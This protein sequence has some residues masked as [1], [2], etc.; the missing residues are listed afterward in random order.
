MSAAAHIAGGAVTDQEWQRGS[1]ARW[2][3]GLTLWLKGGA[4]SIL[5]LWNHFMLSAN[6]TSSYK[7]QKLTLCMFMWFCSLKLEERWTPVLISYLGR[8]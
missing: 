5:F 2:S 8:E 3:G 6:A 4:L 1:G 7:F